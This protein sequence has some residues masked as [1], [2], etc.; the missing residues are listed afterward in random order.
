MKL[1]PLHPQIRSEAAARHCPGCGRLGEKIRD[2]VPPFEEWGCRACEP[3]AFK[4][5]R[6]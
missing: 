3:E 4:E 6:R 5:G 2:L 1:P